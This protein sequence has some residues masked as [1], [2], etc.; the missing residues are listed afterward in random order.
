[1]T[2]FT[3]LPIEVRCMIYEHAITPRAVLVQRKR[4]PYCEFAREYERRH[5][6]TMQSKGDNIWVYLKWNASNEFR[7]WSRTR[8]PALLHTCRESRGELMRLGY[9]LMFATQP[10]EPLVW[11][12]CVLDAI[13]LCGPGFPAGGFNSLHTGLYQSSLRPRRTRADLDAQMSTADK[14]EIRWVVEPIDC[15]EYRYTGEVTG[16]DGNPLPFLALD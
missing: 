3:S 13:Y 1:M 12:N 14:A 15:A 9:R 4:V 11:F 7:F 10:N 16:F 6:I 2:T 5:N 8:I